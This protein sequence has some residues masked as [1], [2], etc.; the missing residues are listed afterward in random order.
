MMERASRSFAPEVSPGVYPMASITVDDV[1]ASLL[2]WVNRPVK[3]VDQEGN[4]IGTFEPVDERRLH[5]DAECP[6]S[7]N[8]LRRRARKGG[9]RSL[10]EILATLENRPRD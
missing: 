6:L 3:I 7:E 2:R 9:G 1:T 10:T 4:W 5:R 8:E